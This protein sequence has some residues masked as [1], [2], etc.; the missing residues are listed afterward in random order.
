M[1]ET[2]I[3][4]TWISTSSAMG[5]GDAVFIPGAS[6]YTKDYTAPLQ[7]LINAVA[8][9]HGILWDGKYMN[10]GLTIPGL[11]SIKALPGCGSVLRVD[12]NCNMFQNTHQSRGVGGSQGTTVG[13]STPATVG[14]ITDQ[15]I[16]IDG[17]TWDF[18]TL[19]QVQA[20]CYTY[21]HGTQ[22]WGVK[23]TNFRNMTMYDGHHWYANWLNIKEDNNY[24]INSAAPSLYGGAPVG[25]QLNGPGRFGFLNNLT[26]VNGC[27]DNWAFNADDGVPIFPYPF[28]GNITDV[29]VDGVEMIASGLGFRFLSA[30]SLIDR[31]TIKGV[32]GQTRYVFALVNN[33]LAE[34]SSTT[35]TGNFGSISIDDIC[36]DITQLGGNAGYE[37]SHGGVFMEAACGDF[38]ITNWRLNAPSMTSTTLPLIYVSGQNSFAKTNRLNVEFSYNETT[39]S[40]AVPLIWCAGAVGT[41]SG[42]VST[43]RS[44][45][46]GAGNQPLVYVAT[47]NGSFGIDTIDMHCDSRNVNSLVELASGEINDCKLSGRHLLANGN[48]AVTVA[49]G[50]TIKNVDTTQLHSLLVAGKKWSGSGSVTNYIDGGGT[51]SE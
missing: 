37:T 31:I 34:G 18:N 48:A 43:I 19:R 51:Y 7:S 6:T 12:A 35:G 1:A 49:S 16:E 38:S 3:P 11:T 21:L 13:G 39:A 28:P 24:T 10:T 15:W 17:G 9:S 50:Y 27:D 26:A 14:N 33:L 45:A 5:P 20:S 41:I 32:R 8:G 4:T 22:W 36:L 23:H 47:G 29:D 42:N 2:Y 25:F 40:N 30:A 44:N 46:I